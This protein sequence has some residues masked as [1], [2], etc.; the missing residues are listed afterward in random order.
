MDPASFNTLDP[1]TNTSGATPLQ[2][3]QSKIY[4]PNLFR[5]IQSGGS[6]NI[7]PTVNVFEVINDRIYLLQLQRDFVKVPQ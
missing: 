2:G 7:Y 1:N 5:V 4:Q 6:V 3:P